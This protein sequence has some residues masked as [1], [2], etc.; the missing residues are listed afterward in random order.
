[1]G[2]LTINCLNRSL[3]PLCQALNTLTGKIFA[4]KQSIVDEAR[5][6]FVMRHVWQIWRVKYNM[7]MMIV[8]DDDD[9]WWCL[10]IVVDCWWWWWTIKFGRSLLTKPCFLPFKQRPL[11]SPC[12]WKTTI[13]WSAKKDQTGHVFDNTM[14]ILHLRVYIY[15]HM[16]YIYIIYTYDIYHIYMCIW[17]THTHTYIY[18]C[19]HISYIYIYTYDIYRTNNMSQKPGKPGD[20]Q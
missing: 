15:I 12:V 7:M 9:D 14:Y 18:I 3:N 5:R 11:T 19:M 6:S 4:V 17:H 20:I 2:K 16:T 13:A 1:M 8:D 10:T